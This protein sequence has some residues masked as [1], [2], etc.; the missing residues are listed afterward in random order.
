MPLAVQLA[1]TKKARTSMATEIVPILLPQGKLQLPMCILRIHLPT[2]HD[3]E[4]GRPICFL[5]LCDFAACSAAHYCQMATT[6]PS[7]IL[8][9][10]SDCDETSMRHETYDRQQFQFSIRKT[11]SFDV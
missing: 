10:Q 8:T 11:I 7:L 3:T 9:T 2:P 5:A 6:R 1:D 4:T